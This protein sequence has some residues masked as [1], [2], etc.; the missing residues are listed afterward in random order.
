MY[1]TLV[2]ISHTTLTEGL[3]FARRDGGGGCMSLYG[4]IFEMFTILTVVSYYGIICPFAQKP[5]NIIMMTPIT[6][7]FR[8]PRPS[9]TRGRVSTAPSQVIRSWCLEIRCPLHQQHPFAHDREQVR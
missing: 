9:S 8:A 2:N 1:S 4:T 6:V 3:I 7:P 5:L